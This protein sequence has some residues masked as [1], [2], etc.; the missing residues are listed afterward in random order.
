MPSSFGRFSI[1]AIAMLVAGACTD[2]RT[3]PSQLEPLTGS[4]PAALTA[5]SLGITP[6]DPTI[7]LSETQQFSAIGGVSAIASGGFH[8][9]ALLL[10]G[11]VRCWGDGGLG[12]LGNGANTTSATPVPV[13]N[14]SGVTVIGMGINHSCAILFNG[15]AQCWGYNGTGMLGNGSTMTSSTPVVVSNLTGAVEITGGLGHTCALIS[16]G[17]VRC[18]GSNSVG[19]LGDGTTASST[20]PV[21]VANLSGGAIDVAV[22]SSH[23][24][25][26]IADGTV[27]CWGLN[28][29]GQLG[30]GSTIGS[31]TPTTV[32][33]LSGAT[34]VVG[35]DNATCALLNDGTVKCW[36]NNSS[37]EL[38]IVPP[39]LLLTPVAIS[40][41][42]GAT[43][44]SSLAHHGC[45]VL[46]DGT[47]KCWGFNH[48][49]QLGDGTSSLA[50]QTPVAVTNLA[51]VTQ[52]SAGNGLSCALTVDSSVKCWGNIVTGALGPGTPVN[53]LT[54]IPMIGLTPPVTWNS[55]D[56]NVAIID[57]ISG[58]ATGVAGGTTTITATSGSISATTTLSVH[59]APVVTTNPVSQTLN[60]GSS[61]TFTAAASG[62]PVPTVQWQISTDGGTTF[63]DMSGETST[64]L[65]FTAA[66]SHNGNQ[67]RA[68]F[69]NVVSQATTTAATLG[70][71]DFS[72]SVT[73]N[74]IAV[75]IGHSAGY[76]VRVTPLNGFTGTVALT[77]S[78]GPPSAVC[79]IVPAALTLG[80]TATAKVTIKIRN[81][82]VPKG[83]FTFTV[84]GTSGT[85][86]RSATMQLMVKG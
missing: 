70:I 68:V 58:L 2:S 41:L 21:T 24:C 85:V 37:S 84:T 33:G 16:D 82:G 39:G 5:G 53:S 64:T 31:V 57:P 66:P 81:L 86:V 13:S 26:V 61:V 27:Q 65:T 4:G 45:A 38:G 60:A 79:T 18:W 11:T 78:G 77:C 73:S 74:S 75:P 7:G 1:A 83:T 80:G 17:T 25:A 3:E 50:A 71:R 76:I 48:S 19:Q 34:A 42:T 15:T 43:M 54:P 20:T 59:T 52:I 44:L 35:V 6:T 30:N 49:G 72:I 12:Q 8:S 51:G 10:D 36:G 63:T 69:T 46:A 40:N 28:F 55:S 22:G 62:F 29:V 9:C 32:S 47:A 67:F 23:S 56:L 14:L